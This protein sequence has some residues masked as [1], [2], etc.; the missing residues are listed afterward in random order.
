MMPNTG[1]KNS[2]IGLHVHIYLERVVEKVAAFAGTPSFGYPA[3]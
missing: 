3:C 2:I 1:W